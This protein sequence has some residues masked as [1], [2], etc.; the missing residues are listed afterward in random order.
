MV[1]LLSASSILT[2]IE[3]PFK[4]KDC[5]FLIVV[6]H[7]PFYKIRIDLQQSPDWSGITLAV[8]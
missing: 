4:V 5:N 2:G 3:Q 1:M 6:E 7:K 8:Q